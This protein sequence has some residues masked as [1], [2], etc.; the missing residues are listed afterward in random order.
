MTE[1]SSGAGAARQQ[2]AQAQGNPLGTDEAAMLAQGIE[3]GTE[4]VRKSSVQVK[5]WAEEHPGQALLVALGAGFVLG[6]LLFGGRREKVDLGLD[7]D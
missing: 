5:A 4:W 2:G 7:L 3:L 6:K 1:Q